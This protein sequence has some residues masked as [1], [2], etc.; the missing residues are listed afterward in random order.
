MHV[1]AA[2]VAVDAVVAA[3]EKPDVSVVVEAVRQVVE[4]AHKDVVNQ[5]DV[6]ARDAL[7]SVYFN[8]GYNE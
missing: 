7:I 2:F 4:K 8:G 1:Q 5:E 6:T 3:E